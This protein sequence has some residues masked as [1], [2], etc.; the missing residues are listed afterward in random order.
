MAVDY[1]LVIIGS[2]SEGIYAATTAVYLN[3]RVALV[4]QNRKG[5]LDNYESIFS[6]TLSQITHLVNQTQIGEGLTSRGSAGSVLAPSACTPRQ[7]GIYPENLF[8]TD[9]LQQAKIWTEAVSANLTIENSLTTLAALG[10]DVIEGEGEFCRLPEQALIVG[11]RKLRS[12][13]YLLATSSH[14]V[15]DN[16]EGIEQADYLSITDFFS[17]TELISFPEQIAII[18][19]LA[20]GETVG[21]SPLTL[22]LTQSLARLGKQIFLIVEE[23]R[24]LPQEDPEVSTLIQALL[25]AEGVKILT[26]S[27]VTQIKN[28]EGKKWLQAGKKAIATDAIIFTGKRQPNIAGLNLA[29]VGVKYTPSRIEVNQKLQTNNPS[30]Y[31]CGSLIGGYDLPHLARYEANIALKNAL[32][33]P[34]FKIDY[35]YVPW[36]LFTEPNFARVGMTETQARRRYGDD[37]YVVRQYYKGV[38]QAQICGETTGF[39]QFLIHSNGEIL[40]AYIIGSQAAETI[41]A[42]ALATQQKIKLDRNIVKG[43]LQVD[44]PYVDFSFTEILQQT[45]T[46]FYQQKLK[47]SQWRKLLNIWFNWR[48]NC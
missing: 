28:L 29:G 31:A 13:A 3:A 16:V 1:D 22:E 36:T 38:T 41:G 30:I 12:R 19:R 37:V 20:K 2:S 11:K 45:A 26:A 7:F 23:E 18:N 4:T 34:W 17:Q 44:F 14:T 21:C 33:L 5:Y 27:K 32:F 9:N 43:L 15:V 39:C 46:L 24:I 35:R 40:G 47:Q 25:E 10:V 42:I 48:R 6:R 8:P